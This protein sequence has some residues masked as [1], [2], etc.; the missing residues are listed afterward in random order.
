MSKLLW[1]GNAPW[2]G[3]GY[4]EQAALFLPRFQADGHEVACI[5]NWGLQATVMDWKGIP[6]L[7][8]FG[9]KD[10]DAIIAWYEKIEP[11]VVIA[12]CDAWT[13]KPRNYAGIPLACWAPVDHNPLPPAVHATLREPNVRPIAM[14]RFGEAEMRKRKLEP[15]YVPHGIDTKVMRPRTEARAQMRKNMGVPQNAFLVGMVAANSSHGEY[16]RKGHPQAFLAFAEFLKT[17]PDAWL[18]VYSK[19][20][21][22]LNLEAM[23]LTIADINGQA[24]PMLSE[25]RVRFPPDHNWY[26]GL[27]R[28]QMAE[29]YSA[30]DVLLNPSMGEGFGVPIL[31]AQ[32]CGVPVIASD[33]SSMT[34]I[35]QA[36]WLVVGDP[37][38]DEAQQSFGIVASVPSIVQALEAAYEARGNIELRAA[39]TE[40]AREYDADK[41]LEQYWVPTLEALARPREIP[42]LPMAQNGANRAERRRRAKAK[43]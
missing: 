30:F 22:A 11:D 17:H 1:F 15:L 9:T 38:W 10:N 14:S 16:P 31:E 26:V 18:Y 39:A 2:C 29:M 36:G 21:D 4:G 33:H 8:A 7:P 28:E 13:L 6:V 41:V 5:A 20:V 34:E 12:L 35:T 43:R 42:P 19:A 24:D 40:V 27:S 37:W 25:R 32:A 3:S 23:L